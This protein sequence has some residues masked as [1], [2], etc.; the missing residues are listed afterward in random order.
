MN[1]LI[2]AQFFCKH[3]GLGCDLEACVKEDPEVSG[4]GKELQK[5]TNSNLNTYIHTGINPEDSSS[6]FGA[7]Q[8]IQILDPASQLPATDLVIESVRAAISSSTKCGLDDL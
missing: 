2:S 8:R 1:P 6:Q 5:E 7:T 3:F 4:Q